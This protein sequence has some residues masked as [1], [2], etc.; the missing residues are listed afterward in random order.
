MLRRCSTP[1]KNQQTG[2]RV[3]R[4][5]SWGLHQLQP[6][7]DNKSLR[8]CNRQI[9]LRPIVPVPGDF[10]DVVREEAGSEAEGQERHHTR[11]RQLPRGQRGPHTLDRGPF[12]RFL[13]ALVRFPAAGDVD[14]TAPFGGTVA[15]TGGGG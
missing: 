15:G 8:K 11:P 13:R 7:S 5:R 4:S 9:R 2:I 12:L 10:E 3:V 6:P 1:T 14:A